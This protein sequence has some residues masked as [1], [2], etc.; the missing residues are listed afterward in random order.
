MKRLTVRADEVKVYD[1]LHDYDADGPGDAAV[2]SVIADGGTVEVWTVADPDG[3]P[4]LTLAP[5]DQVEVW[6]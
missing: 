3:M 1:R 2:Y 4:A 6:R 5:S